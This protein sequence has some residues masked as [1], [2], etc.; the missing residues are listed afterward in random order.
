M[1][2]REGI[3]PPTRRLRVRLGGVP[4]MPPFHFALM[5]ALALIAGVLI[6]VGR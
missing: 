3:E 1:V 2:S 6:L 4:W 5:A